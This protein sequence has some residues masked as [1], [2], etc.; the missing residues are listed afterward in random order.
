MRRFTA[1][2]SAALVCGLTWL[3]SFNYSLAA[4]PAE[5]LLVIVNA[6][7]PIQKLSNYE[8]EAIF[9]R[10][11][12]RWSDGSPVYPFSYP[13]G[14]AERETFDRVVLRLSS[15]QVGRFWLDRRIRGLGLP[16][17]QV[18]T[19]VLMVQIVA[20]LPGA[21]GYFAGTR[22]RPGVRVIARIASGKV[23]PP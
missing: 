6:A 1:M 7:S 22:A 14:S 16:P 11:Q 9:T 19:P 5:P 4:E 10:T 13:A 15:E 20:N 2:L 3:A 21:I 8:L 23:L 18:P 12:T 17:K